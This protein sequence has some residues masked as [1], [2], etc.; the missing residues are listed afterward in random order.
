MAQMLAELRKMETELRRKDRR[1]HR[2]RQRKRLRAL[3]NSLKALQINVQHCTRSANV[4]LV[5]PRG[6]MKEARLSPMEEEDLCRK[7]KRMML[8]VGGA[9]NSMS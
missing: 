8:D 6:G 7:I 4:Q 3:T 9:Q 5:K 2:R 1:R